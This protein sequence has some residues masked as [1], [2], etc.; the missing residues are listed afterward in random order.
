MLKALGVEF[1]APLTIGG[2]GRKNILAQLELLSLSPT[3]VPRKSLRGGPHPLKKVSRTLQSLT[4]R[5]LSIIS[6]FGR[7]LFRKNTQTRK[8]SVPRMM[9]IPVSIGAREG[10]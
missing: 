5:F 10:L 6:C 7:Y 3:V 9:L 4:C 8:S 1:E 2:V